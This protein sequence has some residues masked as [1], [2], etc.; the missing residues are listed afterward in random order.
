MTL[1]N[2]STGTPTRTRRSNTTRLQAAFPGQPA[3]TGYDDAAVTTEVGRLHN[4]VVAGNVDFPNQS[5]DYTGVGSTTPP[6]AA[7]VPTG[8]AGLP[9]TA[10][11]PNVISPGAGS[12]NPAD[13]ADPSA[14]GTP[15]S[16]GAGS[17]IMPGE[18]SPLVA[19][20]QKGAGVPGN[21]IKGSSTNPPIR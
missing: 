9:W 15:T 1:V 13:M 11:T 21:L 3:L 4:G 16:S 8:P 12:L 20:Q 18:T 14:L 10:H 19:D 5:L 2:Y 7:D 17:T 6:V